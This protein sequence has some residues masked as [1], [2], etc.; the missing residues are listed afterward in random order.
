M[1][2]DTDTWFTYLTMF[3]SLWFY[4]LVNWNC[5][6]HS[7]QM[8][9]GWFFSSIY[10]NYLDG[11]WL[12]FNFPGLDS[13][14]YITNTIYSKPNTRNTISG[15]FLPI[16]LYI[17]TKLAI[18]IK[19]TENKLS[20]NTT[21]FIEYLHVLLNDTLKLIIYLNFILYDNILAIC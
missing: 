21:N 17:I 12:F 5:T 7:K 19:Y 14:M 20:N 15:Y 3:R 4:Y 1:I 9:F 18:L 2:I 11:R 8:C 6:W 13:D 10:I 16:S